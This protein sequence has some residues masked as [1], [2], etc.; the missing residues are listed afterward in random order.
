VSRLVFT[1]LV[2]APAQTPPPMITGVIARIH[3]GDL[4][5][6]NYILQEDGDMLLAEDG[7]PLLEES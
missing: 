3:A 5:H 2:Q 7:Q 4:F 1:P 6:L